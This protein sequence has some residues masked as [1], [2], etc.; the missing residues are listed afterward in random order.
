MYLKVFK[1]TI[2]KLKKHFGYKFLFF[3]IVFHQGKRRKNNGRGHI[4]F[5]H[6]T[7]WYITWYHPASTHLESPSYTHVGAWHQLGPHTD[8]CIVS[9]CL[10]S[11]LDWC[12][13]FPS[14]WLPDGSMVYHY[15]KFSVP[16]SH[17]AAALLQSDRS[18][19]SQYWFFITC[20]II[21]WKTHLDY[22]ISLLY[23]LREHARALYCLQHISRYTWSDIRYVSTLYFV[24]F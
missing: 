2:A 18:I 13:I 16:S 9:L 15:N 21:P 23:H 14:V 8:K 20:D 11:T 19:Y 6:T 10:S 7:W 5:D 12:S 24:W 4:F 22:K 1:D 3:V 17:Q